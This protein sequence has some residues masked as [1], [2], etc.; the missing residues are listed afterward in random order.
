V[1]AV[2][3]IEKPPD[4]SEMAVPTCVEPSNKTTV[5]VGSVLLGPLATVPVMLN[6]A[7]AIGVADETDSV[8]VVGVRTTATDV[9]VLLVRNTP[10]EGWKV[11]TT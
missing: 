8:V 10:T 9:E 4:A 5:P 2:T 7:P 3:G 1:A 6:V 11:A